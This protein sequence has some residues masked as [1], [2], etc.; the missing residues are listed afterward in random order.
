MFEIRQEEAHFS[1]MLFKQIWLILMALP[2]VYDPGQTQMIQE[3]P[4]NYGTI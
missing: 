4:E 1:I 2:H 3:S